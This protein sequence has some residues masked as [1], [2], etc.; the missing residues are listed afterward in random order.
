MVAASFAFEADLKLLT[1][2]SAWLKERRPVLDLAVSL[3]CYDE[4]SHKLRLPCTSKTFG[5][6]DAQR[7]QTLEIC[8]SEYV[9]HWIEKDVNRPYVFQFIFPS[10][11]IP[12]CSAQNLWN[13]FRR[14][15]CLEPVVEFHHTLLER[16]S[17]SGGLAVDIDSVDGA[18]GNDLLHAALST[19]DPDSSQSLL[20]VSICPL[21]HSCTP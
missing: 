5:K 14:L 3:L 8:V 4:T 18:S 9:F 15:K 16:A 6:V 21:F 1:N 13:R 19:A 10:E 17:N 2:I 12:S 7:A 11:A 20:H